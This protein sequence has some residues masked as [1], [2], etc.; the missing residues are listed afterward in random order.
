MTH[1]RLRQLALVTA[2]LDSVKQLLVYVLGTSLVFEDPNVVQFGLKNVILPLGGDFMEVVS[3]IRTWTTA[4]RLLEKRGDGGYMI[5]MQTEDA[6]KC[7]EY[8]EEMAS[9]RVIWSHEGPNFI[10]VQCHPKDI[11]GGIMAELDSHT[12]GPDNHTPLDTHF[13]PWHA[14]GPD[15]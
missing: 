2:D 15:Y 9:T 12:P 7:R 11:L 5:I 4:G 13:S 14:C 8:I 1:T 3:P 10:C 6:K